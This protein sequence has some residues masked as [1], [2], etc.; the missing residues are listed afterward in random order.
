MDPSQRMYFCHWLLH[1][2]ENLIWVQEPLINN[3]FNVPITQI[4]TFLL[5][6]SV[7]VLFEGVFEGV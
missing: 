5:F 6:L 4:Y 1:F 2:F 3:W 7:S